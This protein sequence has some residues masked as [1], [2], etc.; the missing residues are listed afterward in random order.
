LKSGK[1]LTYRSSSATIA[2]QSKMEVWL[3]MSEVKE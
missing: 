1:W 2:K 3:K